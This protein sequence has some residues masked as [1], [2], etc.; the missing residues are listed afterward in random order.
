MFIWCW[1]SSCVLLSR[2]HYVTATVL[3]SIN[4]KLLLNTLQGPYKVGQ[5]YFF[6][7]FNKANINRF[8]NSQ[9]YLK[10][11]QTFSQLK[12]ALNFKHL[13]NTQYSKALLLHLSVIQNLHLPLLHHSFLQLLLPSLYLFPTF[14]LS[15]GADLKSPKSQEEGQR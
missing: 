4:L 9:C 5:C 13:V 2:Y 8:K 6:L 1:C 14:L 7:V 12:I 15:F 11:S 3:G 10:Y